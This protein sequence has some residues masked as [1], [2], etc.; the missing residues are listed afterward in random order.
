M[1]YENNLSDYLFV[2]GIKCA[3]GGFQ[4]GLKNIEGHLVGDSLILNIN[5]FRDTI[6]DRVKNREMEIPIPIS[7]DSELEQKPFNLTPRKFRRTLA[8]YIAREPF[9]MVGGMLHFKHVGIAI[10]EGYAGTDNEWLEE[11]E[12]EESIASIDFLEEMAHDLVAGELAGGL[13]QDLTNRFKNAF[14]GTVGD[15]P[16]S[17][18]KKWLQSEI[19]IIYP[20]KFNL[21]IFDPKKAMCLMSAHQTKPI[22]NMCDP[23][24]CGNSCIGKKHKP[25]WNDRLLEVNDLLKTKGMNQYQIDAL[26]NERSEILKAIKLADNEV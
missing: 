3:T 4:A 5:L 14:N 10:F 11:C 13:G 7:D 24:V 23:K 21:C 22:T 15:I 6:N 16:A 20:A 9:G 2:D 1:V 25:V 12:E 18:V 8:R 26:K 19:Y 17:S